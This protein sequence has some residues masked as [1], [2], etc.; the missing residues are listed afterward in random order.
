MAKPPPRAEFRGGFATKFRRPKRNFVAPPRNSPRE[1]P[2]APSVFS[3]VFGGR[4]RY[5][6]VRA[7][8]RR[9]ELRAHPLP[10]TQ[11]AVAT[12]NDLSIRYR[13]IPPV[14]CAQLRG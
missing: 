9:S 13:A 1:A 8:C 3:P 10:Y 5:W 4:F 12:R 14:T 2:V 7:R 6:P 11:R